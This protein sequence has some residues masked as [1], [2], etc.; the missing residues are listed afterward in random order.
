MPQRAVLRGGF[1]AVCHPVA[2]PF[3]TM[4]AGSG[5][6]RVSHGARA[7]ALEMAH[8]LGHGLRPEAVGETFN[9]GSGHSLDIL[10]VATQMARE[11]GA[12]Q[13]EPQVTGKY[14]VG[15]IRHC[16][17]DIALAREVLGYAPR[18]TLAE[19]LVELAEWI[20]GQ[21]AS[22]RVEHATSELAR[23]GLRL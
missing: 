3:W 17:A 22:D 5:G 15:D 16:Y 10:E 19:G 12:S 4:P 8:Q 13:L 9:I 18:Y 7:A 6:V 2:S 23:R 21:T 11:L 20:A 1:A 14:R